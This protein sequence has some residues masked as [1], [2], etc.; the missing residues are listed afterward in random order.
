MGIR[1][2]DDNLI[3]ITPFP[4]T[5]T[6]KNLKENGYL[7]INFVDNIYLYCLA[8]LKEKESKL[9][10]ESF[11]KEL[12]GYKELDI[13]KKGSSERYKLLFPYIKS[14]WGV[15]IGETF[16]EQVKVKKDKLGETKLTEFKIKIFYCEKIKESY[17][18]FNRAE[19]LTLECIIL[20][21]RINVAKQKDDRELLK[22]YLIQFNSM[23]ETVM[24]ISDL[25][26]IVKAIKLVEEYV[27]SL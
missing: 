24:R 15:L 22:N 25:E 1:L 20:A 12:Y 10:I 21:T 17:K 27:N 5:K 11:P 9:G 13:E 18:L 3:S 7:T 2:G 23:V 4:D 19:N 14:A 16:I 8:A 6:F 26:N